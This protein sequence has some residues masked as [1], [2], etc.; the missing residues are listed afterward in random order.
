ME[1]SNMA[2]SVGWPHIPS[3][4]FF[5]VEL[6]K[7]SHFPKTSLAATVCSALVSM[8]IKQDCLAI[9][10]G[11]FKTPSNHRDRYTIKTRS[12]KLYFHAILYL[13]FSCITMY[14]PFFRKQSL[15]L[16]LMI[17]FCP[18]T[19]MCCTCRLS[20]KFILLLYFLRE[21]EK[22]PFRQHLCS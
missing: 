22:K 7:P 16:T 18:I 12:I 4:S 9:R 1:P 13:N 8:L 17:V 6:R 10:D 20:S 11:I 2:V 15:K 21:K 5:T 14:F 19:G 3:S